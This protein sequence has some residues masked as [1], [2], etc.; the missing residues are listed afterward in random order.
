MVHRG[1]V[2]ALLFDLDN[3]IYP[4]STGMERDIIARMTE[5]IAAFLGVDAAQATV[6][7]RERIRHYGTTLEW[8]VAEHGL[9]DVDEYFAAVHPEGEEYCLASDPELALFLDSV[10]LPKAIFTNAPREHA[11]RVLDKLGV[12]D[13]F[14]AVY[15]IRFCGF[16][17]KP[18][19]GSYERV[20]ADFGYPASE[21]FFV[22][23]LRQCV[24]GFYDM[25]GYAALIDEAGR[26]ADWPLPRITRLDELVDIL[27]DSRR[28]ET[29]RKPY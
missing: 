20:L 17:G 9:V 29:Y 14:S 11:W 22:D 12:A 27:P 25:G 26:Y 13:C 23:D 28:L 16:Q 15:D 10:A 7:R 21:V 8:L 4:E 2:R 3:T 6:M 5:Y 18:H 19:R 1:M 24:R